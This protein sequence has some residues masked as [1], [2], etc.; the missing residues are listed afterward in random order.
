MPLKRL[1][2]LT[3]G[4]VLAACSDSPYGSNG[5]G[6]GGRSTTITVSNDFFNPTPDSVVAGQV[7]FSWSNA[8]H[9]HNV[10]WDAGP[11][12][13]PTSS[14]TMMSETYQP[15]LAAGTY[16]YHCTV[17]GTAST[18]MRGRIVVQ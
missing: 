5:G 15:T 8:S 9:G 6:S 12:T 4:L 1:I 18:G 2:L 17:H 13:L 3:A 10:T 7:T 16:T 11:G 14:L